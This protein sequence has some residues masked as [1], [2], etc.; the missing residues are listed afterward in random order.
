MMNIE[1]N[2]RTIEAK[3]GEMILAALKRAGISVPTLCH[4]EGLFPSGACRMCVVEV[5]GV[6]GLVPSCAFPVREGM[7]VKTHSPRALRAR[8]TII[9]LLFGTAPVSCR[10]WLK[11]WVSGSG[12]M[13]VIKVSIILTRQ[14]RQLSV[15]RQNVFSVENA[16]GYVKKFRVSV[17]LIL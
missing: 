6:P 3:P 4:I 15:I 14:I 1:V 16:S 13:P 7:K 11:N 5:E 8:K 12:V 9:E 10:I 17:P 2:N